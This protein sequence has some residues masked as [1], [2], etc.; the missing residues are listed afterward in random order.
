MGITHKSAQ[1]GNSFWNIITAVDPH[2]HSG[3]RLL[4]PGTRIGGDI[5]TGVI[6]RPQTLL[7]CELAFIM[8]NRSRI[9]FSSASNTN[10]N[11]AAILSTAAVEGVMRFSGTGVGVG[12]GVG[13]GFGS[14]LG[15]VLDP[16]SD[17]GWDLGWDPGWV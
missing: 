8:F 2:C 3:Q 6:R 17:L 13:F 12:S 14:V 7:L 1:R 9:L 15:L 5:I 10:G 4:K 16:A 11:V